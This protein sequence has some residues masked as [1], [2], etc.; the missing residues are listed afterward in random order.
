VFFSPIFGN[1]DIKTIGQNCPKDEQN[2]KVKFTVENNFFE[3]KQQEKK[4]TS[5]QNLKIQS[6]LPLSTSAR[7]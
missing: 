4:N 5:N 6:L 7:Q 3:K 2:G 1:C